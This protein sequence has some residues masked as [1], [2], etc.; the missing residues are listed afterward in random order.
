MPTGDWTA[1]TSQMWKSHLVSRWEPSPLFTSLQLTYLKSIRLCELSTSDDIWFTIIIDRIWPEWVCCLLKVKY[2]RNTL[3]FQQQRPENV[4]PE[5]S[6]LDKKNVV[7]AQEQMNAL[8]DSRAARQ[9]SFCPSPPFIERMRCK[10]VESH[11]EL[12]NSHLTS[13]TSANVCDMFHGGSNG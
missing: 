13:L 9:T 8:K 7:P 3:F 4:L 11:S 10:T 2:N 12:D 5:T 1:T 6:K